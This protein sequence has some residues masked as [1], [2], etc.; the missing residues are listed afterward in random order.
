MAMS[1]FPSSN[2]TIDRRRRDQRVSRVAGHRLRARRADRCRCRPDAPADELLAAYKDKIDELNARGGYVTADV[3]DVFPRH[4]GSRRDA[5]PVQLAS[6]GT[7]RTKSGSSS[8]AAAC[9]TSIR[10]SGPVFA[11]EV[12]AGDLIRVPRGHAPLVRP[13][14]RSAHPRDPAVPGSVRLD[15]A[16]HA[17]RRRQGLPAGLLRPG[18]LPAGPPP[19]CDASRWPSAASRVVLLDIEGTTTP[20][21]FVHDVLF[22]YARAH[23]R[24]Y[25]SD[26]R[27][28][29]ATRS[30]IAQT[31]RDRA[32]R[33]SARGGS[34]A[35]VATGD[36]GRRP[37]ARSTRIVGWLMDRD[38]KS[39][40]LEAPAGPDLGT[41]VPGRRAARPG[42]RRRARRACAAGARRASRVAIYSSGSELAQRRLFESTR[43]GDLTPLISTRSSTPAS[44]RKAIAAATRESP[45][46]CAVAPRDDAV[47]LRRHART[48]T[49]RARPGCRSS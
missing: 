36:D 42:V 16:L 9:S 45:R 43:D 28:R 29:R 44:A 39:P 33:G 7:T 15:A 46:R 31:A 13:L 6:T 37:R 11:I 17:E 24:A 38:R 41:R 23:L 10:Q 32:R 27:A 22:P 30:T 35:A 47:R 12:G 1:A 21:A 8:K 4:A 14:R 2:R 48:R 34:P 5:Q 49:P 40:G 20:I 25:L 19:A 18:V 26:P 3:I